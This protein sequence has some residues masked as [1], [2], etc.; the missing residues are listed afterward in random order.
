[1]TDARPSLLYARHPLYE[2][3]DQDGIVY[4]PRVK[5]WEGWPADVLETLRAWNRL[6]ELSFPYV[7]R[8]FS[9]P[10]CEDYIDHR[11]TTCCRLNGTL[12]CDDCLVAKA[13]REN[14]V[15]AAVRRAS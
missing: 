8:V 7:S 1:V 9:C 2:G 15:V 10:F 13:R 11:G 14:E 6:R 12:I 5:S 4:G 3:Q